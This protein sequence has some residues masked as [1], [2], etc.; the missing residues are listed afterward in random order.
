MVKPKT[1]KI[2]NSYV[3][4]G[5]PVYIIAEIGINHN[6]DIEVAKRLM[7]IA[8]SSGANAVKF[9]K[10]NLKKIY[11]P[12]L[13]SDPNSAEWSFHYLLPQLRSYELSE[14][15]YLQINNYAKELGVDL[16]VTPFDLES[17]AFIRTLHLAAVKIS[18][19]D[20][21]NWP[22]IDGATRLKLPLVLSTG[23]WSGRD[24]LG[25]S[26]FVKKLTSDFALLHCQSTYPAPLEAVNLRYLDKLKEYAPVVG[27]SG[28]ERG[29]SVCLA[30]VAMGAKIIEKHLTMDRAQS[31]PDHKASLNPA[32][33][34][35]LVKELRKVEKALGKKRKITSVA[36][37]LTQQVFSK[38]LTA[39]RDLLTGHILRRSD[40]VFLAPGK[41]IPPAH[42][43]RWL[44]KPLTRAKAKYEYLSEDDFLHSLVP[45]GWEKFSFRH[46]WGVKCRFHDFQEY[47]V[48]NYPV[49][50][51][52]CSEEDVADSFN[53]GNKNSSLIIHAPEIIDKELFDL[54]HKTPERVSQSV[55]LLTKTIR[56]TRQLKNKFNSQIPKV[57]VHMGG[58]S[59]N[60]ETYNTR[61][62]MRIAEKALSNIDLQGVDLLPEN[63]PP[64]PWY[65]GGQWYQLAFMH[66]KEILEFCR[67]LG[68]G[69]TL[70]LSHA[71]LYCNYFGQDLLDYIKALLP[72]IRLVHV[73]DASGIDGEGLQIGEGEIE[74]NKVFDLLK[75]VEFSWVPEIWSGHNDHGA[76]F[77]LALKRLSSYNAQL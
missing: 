45:S 48:L 10:R 35:N 55:I 71:K 62:M 74:F 41:G 42:L 17:L 7:E 76:G 27:Y 16:L 47:K 5:Q 37:K 68:L 70:D 44:G 6:G 46:P 4:N 73:S 19:A 20:F 40:V 64:R 15:D 51:F 21:T 63:L 23:I 18:S 31:G 33:F 34:A 24:I 50:E 39:K 58:M 56:K 66:P 60:T 43:R 8:A 75:D 67:S 54:C 61:K 26:R 72:V 49:V 28:H 52:H 59:A 13:L 30:A 22:L 25:T 57:I 12:K 29:I 3:G 1:I 53:D 77:H 32:E 69:M 14:K 11:T 65:L 2:G 36:E 9:Q 38:S